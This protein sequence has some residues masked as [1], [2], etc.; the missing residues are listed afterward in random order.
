M[1]LEKTFQLVLQYSHLPQL[2]LINALVLFFFAIMGA[3]V[4]YQQH[5]TSKPTSI[6]W[7]P[8]TH[9]WMN[10]INRIHIGFHL[11]NPFG[12]RN[13][14]LQCLLGCP[15]EHY[16]LTTYHIHPSWCACWVASATLTL[17]MIEHGFQIQLLAIAVLARI[18][19]GTCSSP[20]QTVSQFCQEAM[21]NCV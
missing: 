19:I 17:V 8:M 6:H 3:R 13:Q 11:G 12:K 14:V 1:T 5:P 20:I 10:L 9:L 4:N 7:M 21:H 15:R 16:F 18:I 2:L